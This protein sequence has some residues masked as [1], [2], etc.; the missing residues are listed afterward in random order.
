MATTSLICDPNDNTNDI[1]QLLNLTKRMKLSTPSTANTIIS[2]ANTHHTSL[3]DKWKFLF[4]SISSSNV[5]CIILTLIYAF[6]GNATTNSFIIA[7]WFRN[8]N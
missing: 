1:S 4:P 7:T 6:I 2:T 8:A 3:V 5:S